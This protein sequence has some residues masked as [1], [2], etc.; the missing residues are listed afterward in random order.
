MK[1]QNPSM[2]SSEVMLCIKKCNGQTDG[3][4]HA[5]TNVPEAICPSK[6]FENGG[7]I[8]VG[9][10]DL[11]THIDIKNAE[12]TSTYSSQIAYVFKASQREVNKCV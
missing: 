8:S 10:C 1:F 3:R 6:F 2:H 4:M 7:I 5:R 11:R 12:T 9:M